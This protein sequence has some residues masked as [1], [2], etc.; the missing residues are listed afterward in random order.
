M[1]RL[2]AVAAAAGD[3]ERD[4]MLVSRFIRLTAVLVD[5]VLVD[6]FDA[7]PDVG[8]FNNT[9]GLSLFLSTFLLEFPLLLI[10]L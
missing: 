7:H 10:L 3:L 1:V 9:V 6:E 8:M 4:F 2:L 5:G